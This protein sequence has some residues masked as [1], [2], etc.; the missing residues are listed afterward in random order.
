MPSVPGAVGTSGH[1]GLDTH[2]TCTLVPQPIFPLVHSS[3]LIWSEK[4]FYFFVV[5][6]YLEFVIA[7]AIFVVINAKQPNLDFASKMDSSHLISCQ[8]AATAS[9]TQEAVI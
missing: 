4:D 6:R 5:M 9:T 7:F 2:T 8:A 1:S 3:L